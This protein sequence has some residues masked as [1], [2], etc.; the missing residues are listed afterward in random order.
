MNLPLR[1]TKRLTPHFLHPGSDSL[2]LCYLLLLF[3]VFISCASSPK[4]IPAASER[5]HKTQKLTT[6]PVARAPQRPPNSQSYYHAILG[7]QYE[8]NRNIGS[9]L[10]NDKNALKEYLIALRYDPDAFFLL[11]RAAILYSRLGNQKDALYYAKRAQEIDPGNGELLILI[12][13]IY[14]TS[15]EREKGL[16]L[17]ENAVK[18]LPKSRDIYFKIAGIYADQG[19]LKKAEEVIYKG[20]EVGPPSPFSHYYLGMLALETHSMDEALD[21]LR[22]ALSVDSYFEPAHMAIANIYERQKDNQAAINVYRHIV[23][24]INPRNQQAI[25]R[26]VQLLV[27]RRA[28]D[29][30][31]ALLTR[32]IRNNPSNLDLAIQLSRVFV[33]KRDFPNAIEAMQAVVKAK[34]NDHRLRLYL[35]T[36]YEEND[37][38]NKALTSY[39]TILE[40]N[41]SEYDVRIRLGSL[42]FYKL[43]KPIEALA[44]GEFAK[45][46]NP[47]RPES[48][49]FTGLIHHDAT[50][51]QEAA[52]A[53]QHG[54]ERNPTI[55]D[56]HFHLGAAYDKLERFDDMVRSMEKTIQLAPGHANALNYLGYTFADKGVR[57][58]EAIDLI[59]RALAVK[60]DDGYFIDSLGWAYYRKGNLEDAIQ[61]LEKAVSL[62]PTDPVIHEHLGEVYLKK[63]LRHL[64]KEAWER[65][66]SL[67]PA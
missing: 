6:T 28:L 64:A 35:A 38:I 62:I 2:R 12:G 66:L 47:Q 43:N 5:L 26:L 48:Y 19:E 67:D 49:L 1:T 46:I 52:E 58:T 37:E 18:A 24:R 15:G 54:I 42:Y 36:L 8:E 29:D 45:K 61:L 33:E 17:Y 59:N 4:N 3:S 32:L 34:P 41:P 10:E 14:V 63:N 50:R 13:D 30:A 60:P 40:Q 11:K 20:I 21:H 7:L 44:Q 53:L 23:N 31:I 16:A 25:N 22:E 9:P 55:P 56:L 39:Q 57:L 27:Q 51:Y 65:S